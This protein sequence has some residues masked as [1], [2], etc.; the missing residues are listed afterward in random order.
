MNNVPKSP[1]ALTHCKKVHTSIKTS[2]GTL[3]I[4]SRC[5]YCVLTA[6]HHSQH[7]ILYYSSFSV[8]LDLMGQLF[9][10]MHVSEAWVPMTL[11]PVHS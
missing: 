9:L 3:T 7:C 5:R 1:N 11:S 8:G 2:V 4:C 10:Y 6:A